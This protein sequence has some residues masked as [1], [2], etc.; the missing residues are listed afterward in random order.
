MAILEAEDDLEIDVIVDPGAALPIDRLKNAD[1]LLIRYGVLSEA[2]AAQ[3]LDLKIVSRH[4]VGCDNL[5]LDALAARG[6]PATIVGPVAA[7]TVAEQVMAMLLSLVKK[8]TPYDTAVRTGNWAIRD[9][10]QVGDLAGRTMMIMGFGRIGREVARRAHAFDMKVMVHD[11]YVGDGGVSAAGY[12]PVDD[13]RAALSSVDVLSLHLPMTPQTRGIVSEAELAVMKN[14]AVV[15]NAAR[16]GLVDE[17]ALYAALTGRMKDGGAALDCFASEPP[18]PDLPLLSLSN[19]VVSPHSA[20]L[21][22]EAAQRMGTVAALNV[23]SGLRGN[24]NPELVFNRRALE[25]AGHGL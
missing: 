16:G 19:V 12:Q 1:A 6:I 24:I 4:G 20:A 13:W 22:E 5:P 14:T 17:D 3:M 10:L 15:I 23:I 21:S 7:V 8:I 2:D 18:S 9:T 11:P 25:E